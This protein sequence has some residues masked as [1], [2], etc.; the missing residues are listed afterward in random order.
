MAYKKR[1]IDHHTW[2]YSTKS[3]VFIGVYYKICRLLFEFR[4]FVLLVVLKSFVMTLFA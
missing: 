4:L 3:R 2:L 1:L